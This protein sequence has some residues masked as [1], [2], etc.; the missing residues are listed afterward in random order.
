MIWQRGAV[1]SSDFDDNGQFDENMA[2]MAKI[3]QSIIFKENE[4]A[5]GPLEKA[6]LTKMANLA[7]IRLCDF[8][9]IRHCENFWT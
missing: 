1:Q 5:K 2:N 7:K 4:M 3:R 6:I 8:L 9:Q